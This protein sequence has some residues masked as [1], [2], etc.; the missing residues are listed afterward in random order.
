MLLRGTES[1]VAADVRKCAGR[2]VHPSVSIVY[3]HGLCMMTY[4]LLAI[5]I[6]ALLL[7]ACGDAVTQR[8]PAIEPLASRQSA[9]S[10][11][12][13]AVAATPLVPAAPQAPVLPVAA[14]VVDVPAVTMTVAPAPAAP[15]RR[16]CGQCQ[17]ELSAGAKF[18]R[19]CGAMF[20]VG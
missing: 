6:V 13:I 20:G 9:T 12:P 2:Y 3:Q 10:R 1:G 18:C 5:S 14:R 8:T 4:R 17:A 19:Q 16:V 7:S 11:E 15:S